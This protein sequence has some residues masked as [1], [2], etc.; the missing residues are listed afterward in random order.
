MSP[1]ILHCAD[2]QLTV[3]PFGAQTLSWQVAGQERLWLS[4]DADLDGHHP[5]RGGVPLCF[6]WFGK[7]AQGPSHGFA[8][9]RLW[10]V[11]EQSQTDDHAHLVLSLEQDADTEALWPHPFRAEMAFTLKAN[12]LQLALTVTNPGLAPL[13]Y[14]AALHSYLCTDVAQL[15]ITELAGLPYHDK[16]TNADSLFEDGPD[17]A[18]PP[19]PVDA[20]VPGL[21]NCRLAQGNDILEIDNQGHDAAVIWNP[22]P[23]HGIG[24]VHFGGEQA[25][26]CI[27]SA[28]ALTPVTLAPGQRHTLSQTLTVGP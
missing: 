27:E 6:P 17:A 19:I 21:S 23:D 10:Q 8:R 3:S 12:A 11:A 15:R 7:A 16:L 22:G 25:F 2:S 1:L 9:T 26:I 18:L 4:L 24:D 28:H 20:I 5:I 14:T 13:S